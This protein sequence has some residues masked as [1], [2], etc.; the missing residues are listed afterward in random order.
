MT[1]DLRYATGP[2][3]VETATTAQLRSRYLIEN[4]FAPAEVRAAY[5][6]EDRMVVAGAV[7]AGTTLALPPLDIVGTPGHLDRREL[8]VVNIGEP[9]EVLVDGTPHKLGALDGLYVGR[10]SDVAFTGDGACFYLVSAPADATHPVARFSRD[11][12]E[13][14]HIGDPA[15]ASARALYRYV[16]GGGHPSCRLQFGVTVV[17]DGSVWNTMPAHLHRRRTE[18]YLYTGLPHDARVLHILGRPGATRHLFVADRQAVIA[19]SWSV[20]AGAG[21]APYAFV[22]AMAGENTDYGDLDPVAVADL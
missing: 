22:W 4:L 17:S 10:G 20:H 8:G 18:V 12:T 5:T 1:V 6:H 9:G 11:T 21:T 3:T 19:P 14:V 7:P 15:T 16:W 2:E 13:P